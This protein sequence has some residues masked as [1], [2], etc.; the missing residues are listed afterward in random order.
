MGRHSSESPLVG[1]HVEMVRSS[2]A[3]GDGLFEPAI[4][5]RRL[6]DP[7][8]GLVLE[9]Q[10]GDSVRMQRTWPSSTIRLSRAHR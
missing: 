4:V 8:F 5:V 6:T 9:V 3:A 2:G 10:F 7:I 1:A